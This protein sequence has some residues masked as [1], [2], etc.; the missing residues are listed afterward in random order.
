MRLRTFYT[1]HK[2]KEWSL[3]GGFRSVYVLCTILRN[4]KNIYI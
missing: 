1:D 3:E 4:K 2:H